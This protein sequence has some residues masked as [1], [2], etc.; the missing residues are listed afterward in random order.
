MC[1]FKF[2]RNVWMN[3][4]D[5]KGCLFMYCDAY[6][7][8]NKM[9]YFDND[10]Q[11]LCEF[12][13]DTCNLTIIEKGH[14]EGNLISNNIF[15]RNGMLYITFC[16]SNGI[17]KFDM[18]KSVFRE[19]MSKEDIKLTSDCKKSYDFQT[20]V[21]NKIWQ[22]PTYMDKPV[23]CYDLSKKQFYQNNMLNRSI[24]KYVK[25]NERTI[26]YA[27]GYDTQVWS[28]I[29]KTHRYLKYDLRSGKIEIF[30]LKDS[31]KH[32]NSICYD[33]E[34]VWL[35]QI[36]STDLI[37]VNHEEYVISIEDEDKNKK[38]QYSKIV[39]LKD[40][41]IVLPRFGNEIILVCKETRAVRKIE[42]SDE[43][44]PNY[45]IESQCSKIVG[46]YEVEEKIYLF[47]WGISDLLLLDKKKMLIESIKIKNSSEIYRKY[48]NDSIKNRK[49]MKECYHI[50][51]S[52][53]ME[54]ILF[55][56]RQEGMQSL[57]NGKMIFRSVVD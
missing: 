46:C 10:L 1:R 3:G 27:S 4:C 16:N 25:T 11:A 47:P 18:E 13:L 49:S 35:T 50:G 54:N 34:N 9:W 22:I 31:N 45:R 23:C 55:S 40:D 42:I 51:L 30:Q 57:K 53:Y 37:C 6:V 20:I 41:I 26:V 2:L 38:E 19:I 21:D 39:N 43:Y 32:L 15:Y 8:G 29:W 14:V 7:N 12:N 33:G 48:I 17:L 5:G 36:D 28:V 56:E 24:E 44:F 52:K